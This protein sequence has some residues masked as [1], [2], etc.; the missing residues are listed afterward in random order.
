MQ[1]IILFVLMII[2]AKIGFS[3]DLITKRD[4][5][6]IFC[7]IT[8]E[9]SVTIY[10]KSLREKKDIEQSIKKVDVLSY[11]NS[12]TIAKEKK[13]KIDTAQRIWQAKELKKGFYKSFT[14][15]I[16]NSPSITKKFVVKERTDADLLLT[17]GSKYNYE[18]I[19][20]D[21]DN[22]EIYGFCDGKDVYINYDHPKGYCK[23]EYIGPYT[24]FTYVIHGMG[25]FAAIPDQLTTLDEKGNFK[26][27][28]VHNLKKILEERCSELAIKY[29]AELDKKAKRIEYLIKLNDYL[30]TKK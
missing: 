8:K 28:T 22:S 20:G 16:T 5:S 23:M 14:E 21:I 2:G 17:H 13:I 24:F 26:S 4:S 6:K 25:V 27:T 7:K 9:D 11:F 12:A 29:E 19:E 15:F 10:Y 18:L 3:Q 1:R 30:K